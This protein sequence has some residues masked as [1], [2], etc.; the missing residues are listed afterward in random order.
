MIFGKTVA[1]GPLTKEQ[2]ALKASS[3]T[4]LQPSKNVLH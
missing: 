1:I 3:L 4:T 2:M